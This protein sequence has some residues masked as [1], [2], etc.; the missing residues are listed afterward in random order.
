MKSRISAQVPQAYYVQRFYPHLWK[1]KQQRGERKSM[2]WLLV[3]IV[4]WW[5]NFPILPPSYINLL[6][7]WRLIS[8]PVDWPTFLIALR[9]LHLILKFF[10]WCQAN[11]LKFAQSLFNLNSLMW[12]KRLTV[13]A[14]PVITP[15]IKSLLY[16]AVI[17]QTV[18]ES[19]E[20]LSPFFV[21]LKKDGTYR[22]TFNLKNLKGHCHSDFG[23]FWSK[24][25]WN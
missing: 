16:K 9:T 10:I 23:N 6:W 13:S 5:M 17:F 25:S 19:G 11:V 22:M 12:V 14:M 15:E 1:W 7:H 18:R 4:H 8:K 20:F 24:L 3:F 21:R 2:Q